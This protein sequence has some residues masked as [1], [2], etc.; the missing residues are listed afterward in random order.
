MDNNK[1]ID[2]Q[3]KE[4]KR[5]FR[6]MMNGMAAQSMRAKGLDYH[7]NWGVSLPSLRGKAK[8]IGKNYGLA[9]ALWK[10]D[11]RE[12]KILATM[13]MPPDVILPDVVDIWMEQTHTLE[14]AEQAAFNLYQHLPYAAE[15]A[16]KW[17]ASS[18]EI[19]QIC[20]YHVLSRLFIK[21][22]EPNERGINEFI[23][24]A[25]S[26][27]MSNSVMLK[28]AALASLMHFAELGIVYERLAKSALA[29]IGYEL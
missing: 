24:Q 20:G 19:E 17:I 11:V 5:S 12:C 29:R 15:K 25:L 18:R 23:D 3:L 26:A 28:K 13:T 14:I 27:V 16:Y 2:E 8:E 6:L 22:Q 4:V 1:A 7:V 10:E 9:L 21:R